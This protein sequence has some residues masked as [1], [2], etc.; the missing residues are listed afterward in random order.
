VT[1]TFAEQGGKTQRTLR[2]LFKSAAE[3]DKTIEFGVTEGGH[4]TLD[5]LEAHLA[6]M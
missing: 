2:M 5:R 3:R 1:V 6:K 4:Q